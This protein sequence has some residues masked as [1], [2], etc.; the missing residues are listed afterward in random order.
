MPLLNVWYEE[1]LAASG[2]APRR[3]QQTDTRLT[4]LGAWSYQASGAASGGSLN[5]T[6]DKGAAVLVSFTGTSVELLGLKGPNYGEILVSLDNGV[7]ESIDMYNATYAH[8][9]SIYKKEG[10]ATPPTRL[11]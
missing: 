2:S 7:A 3:Y 8:Q 10:L 1:F 4:Y 11:S 5:Y 9:Q 6:N